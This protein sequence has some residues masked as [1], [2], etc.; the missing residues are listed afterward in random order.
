MQLLE[1]K[2][3]AS[4]PLKAALLTVNLE[5]Q[6]GG[7][8][9]ISKVVQINQNGLKT[10]RLLKGEGDMEEEVVFRIQGV[11]AGAELPPFEKHEYVFIYGHPRAWW[12][13]KH[14]H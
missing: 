1:G 5:K 3:D 11:V 6:E 13:K 10:W 2:H 7:I 12:L 9:P 4:D 14:K 8:R